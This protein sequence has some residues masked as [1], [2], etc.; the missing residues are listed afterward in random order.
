MN[1]LLST[2]KDTAAANRLNTVESAYAGSPGSQTNFKGS[3]AGFDASGNGQIKVNGQLYSANVI[4]SK[5][6]PLNSG[7]IMRVGKG[8]KNTNW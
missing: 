7:V 5:S 1:N 2:L 4:A 3:W 8:I 6:L